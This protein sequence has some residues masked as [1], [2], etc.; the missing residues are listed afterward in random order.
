MNKKYYNNNDSSGGLGALGVLQIIFI[1]LKCLDLVDWTWT[2][3]FI[4]TFI[5]GAL[6]A[7]ATIVLFVILWRENK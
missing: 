6:L 5:G 3:V 4:P 7:I 1:V 2:Q